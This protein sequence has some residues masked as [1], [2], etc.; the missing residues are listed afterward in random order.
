MAVPEMITFP[1][2]ARAGVG[3]SQKGILRVIAFRDGRQVAGQGC[4]PAHRA[5][6]YH[7]RHVTLI[8]FAYSELLA[9]VYVCVYATGVH[10]AAGRLPGLEVAPVTLPRWTTGHPGVVE[11]P[12]GPGERRREGWG[13][14]KMAAD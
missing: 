14:G 1:L 12:Q 9:R 11:A 10:W 8:S 3:S 6:G 13:T 5:G 2:S 4:R 7:V